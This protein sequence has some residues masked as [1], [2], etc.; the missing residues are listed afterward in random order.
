MKRLFKITTITLLLFLNLSLKAQTLDGYFKY[1]GVKQLSEMAHITNDFESGEYSIDDQNVYVYIKSKDNV[2]GASIRTELSV[3]LGGGG[4]FFTDIYVNYDNDMV[5]PFEAF[6]AF[7]DLFQDI[8]KS[9]DSEYYERIRKQFMESYG[10]DF[11]RWS[12]KTWA[13][14]ALNLDYYSYLLGN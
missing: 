13:L 11:R 9:I 7:T 5:R 10:T 4:L 12:G 2:L 1:R 14:L 8:L 6:G 3:N